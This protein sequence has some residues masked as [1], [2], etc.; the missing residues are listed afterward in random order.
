MTD[1]TAPSSVEPVVTAEGVSAPAFAPMSFL[2]RW[3]ADIEAEAKPMS[4]LARWR[5]DIEA[6]AKTLG[7]DAEKL[8]AWIKEHM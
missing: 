4:F 3:R 7:V 6:E 5:A 2:A 1:D 8:L